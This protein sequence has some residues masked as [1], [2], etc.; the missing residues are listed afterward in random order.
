M[1]WTGDAYWL[2]LSQC[3]DP[4][5]RWASEGLQK[6][7][8]VPIEMVTTDMLGPAVRWDHRVGVH[9]AS[10]EITLSEEKVISSHNTR[11]VLNRLRGIPSWRHFSR[12]HSDDHNYAQTELAAFFLSWLSCLPQ[13]VLNRPTPHGFAGRERHLS[14]WAL[15]TTAVGLQM[16]LYR[17]S[18]INCSEE[19]GDRQLMLEGTKLDTVLVIGQHSFGTAPPDVRSACERLAI[20]ANTAILGVDFTSGLKGS[21]LFAGAT[22]LP[23][24]RV[25]GEPAL[26]ALAEAF[27]AQGVW[28]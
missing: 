23:D 15:L 13:P 20:L 18:S 17:Q 6:R 27:Q 21:W 5:A 1:I 8:L 3:D 9:G 14:E 16:P 28:A 2:I 26:D 25:G 12:F 7:G 19:V 10:I 11:G 24:L 22:P 4:S